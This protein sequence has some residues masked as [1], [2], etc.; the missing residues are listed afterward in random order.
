M[1]AHK[2]LAVIAALGL[3]GCGDDGNATLID[4]A[5]NVRPDSAPPRPM[6]PTLTSFVAS[7]T[8]I[9]AGSAT[10]VTWSWTYGNVPY[11]E[12]T[13]TVDNGVGAVTKGQTTSVTVSSITTFTLTCSNSAGAAMRPVVVTV[14]PVA[15]NLATFVT[16]PTVT[17]IGTP[18]NV[19]WSW[20]YLAPPVPAPT[21]SIPPTVGAVT[22]G[23]TT[24]LTQSSGTTYT[25]TCTS[26][27]GTRTRTAFVNA[28]TAPLI[29][30]FTATPNTVT[31]A[32]PTSVTFA[33][34]F[35]NTP[36]PTASCSIDQ[37]IGT[38]TSGSARSLTLAATTVYTLTCTNTGGSAMQPVT[39]TVP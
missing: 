5:P 9:S 2:L 16:T 36:S 23:Q 39:I 31:A 17:G 30:A 6:A 37:G 34:S 15:P 29:A 26:T 27:S 7:P 25:L 13:C 18:T 33:W 1:N 24:S 11:P 3:V 32:T 10:N 12:P 4:A 22:N 8:S 35:S 20:T 19:T 14:P 21:C 38:I 28:A